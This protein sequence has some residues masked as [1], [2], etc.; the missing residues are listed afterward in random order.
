MRRQG[1]SSYEAA[2]QYLQQQYLPQHNCR[3]ARPPAQPADYHGGKPSRRELRE[4]FR[5]ESPRS[6]SPDWVVRQAGRWLQLHPAA[7]RYGPSQSQA[8]VCEYEDGVVEVYYRGERMGF[9]EIAELGEIA[10]DAMF[11]PRILMHSFWI[12]TP[13]RGFDKAD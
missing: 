5:L 1:I 13:P 4:I 7:R 12:A 10:R 3:F 8:L 11:H 6:I 9:R 2:N